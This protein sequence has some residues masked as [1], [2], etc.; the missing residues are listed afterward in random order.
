MVSEVDASSTKFW[1]GS[2][3]KSDVELPKGEGESKIDL[4]VYF[5]LLEGSCDDNIEILPNVEGERVVDSS[6]KI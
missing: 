3:D 6:S 1:E 2:R 4:S 5:S